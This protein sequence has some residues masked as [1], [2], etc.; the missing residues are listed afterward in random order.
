MTVPSLS[1]N[2]ADRHLDARRQADIDTVLPTRMEIIPGDEIVTRINALL[3]TSATVTVTCL[4]HHGVGRTMRTALQLASHGYRVVPHLAARSL[5]DRSQL[6]GILRDCEVAGITEVFAIA[7]DAPHYAGPYESSISLMEDIADISGG[8]MSIGVAGYPEGHPQVSQLR[9]LD[10]L[11]DKQHLASHV[12]TQMCF[13]APKISGYVQL[14]RREGFQ[15]PVW[16]GVAGPIARSELIPLARKIGVGTSLK[17]LSRQ[18]PLSR[19]LLVGNRYSPESL[20]SELA[21]MRNFV[22]G[23]H[24][25]SFNSLD[26]L[27]GLHSQQAEALVHVGANQGI[28][29]ER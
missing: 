6:A 17:F 15:L 16:A 3:P 13:A 23:V 14:L 25:Y 22:A 1:S 18:G 26:I 19:R 28:S 12:V 7:G 11:L 20:I 27:P 21:L 8:S 10:S 24:L 5:S 4:P 2:F 9:L 29:N